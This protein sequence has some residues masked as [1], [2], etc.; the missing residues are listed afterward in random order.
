MQTWLL[1]KDPASFLANRDIY[2]LHIPMREMVRQTTKTELSKGWLLQKG[3]PASVLFRYIKVW[4]AVWSNFLNFFNFNVLIFF[5]AY[6][7]SCYI[8][9]T[10]VDVTD[11]S[12]L[13]LSLLFFN[14]PKDGTTS[15]TE[16]KQSL[17]VTEVCP[18]SYYPTWSL[19]S[20]CY[21]VL[22]HVHW[23]PAWNVAWLSCSFWCHGVFLTFSLSSSLLITI[24]L[25][26]WL[27]SLSCYVGFSI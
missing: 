13:T 21:L 20:K 17:C 18:Q 4:F 8:V 11:F 14:L 15:K 7:C 22:I 10:S 9:P 3:K 16:G 6:L 2:H 25:L 23:W 5:F 12:L 26:L 27:W 24:S 1:L 19:F